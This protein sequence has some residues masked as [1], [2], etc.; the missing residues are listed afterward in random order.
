M[1]E[2]HYDFFALWGD[3]LMDFP[4]PISDAKVVQFIPRLRFLLTP[5][6][7]IGHRLWRLLHVTEEEEILRFRSHV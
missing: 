7:A 2:Q 1:F 4:Y 5:G 6:I 3:F